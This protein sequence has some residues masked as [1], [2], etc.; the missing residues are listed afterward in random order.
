MLTQTGRTPGGPMAYDPFARG[1]A[2]VGVRTAELRDHTRGGRILPLEL[3]YP[4][5]AA[6]RGQDLDDAVRDHF[7]IA[8]GIPEAAQR[9]VRGAEPAHGRFP[10]I[11]YFHGATGHRRDA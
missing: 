5:D 3:W 1:A 9:A 10:L 6:H 7:A 8:P 11:A 2:P 4:A